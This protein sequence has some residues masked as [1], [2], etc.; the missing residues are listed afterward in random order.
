MNT[1]SNV[2][3]EY[4]KKA[5]EVLARL[6]GGDPTK[7]FWEAL[8]GWADQVKW[9]YAQRVDVYLTQ[10]PRTT[11]GQIEWK[12]KPLGEQ[13][14]VMWIN[15]ALR[16]MLDLWIIKDENASINVFMKKKFQFSNLKWGS[17]LTSEADI[18]S[19]VSLLESVK[20]QLN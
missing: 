20:K 15:S 17:F 12:Y 6:G 18:A 19:I 3:L 5:P 14:V 10:Y 1:L 7:P 9:F 8:I 13:N 4:Q 11:T 2:F 16:M